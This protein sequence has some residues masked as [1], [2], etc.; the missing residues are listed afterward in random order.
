MLWIGTVG[1]GLFSFNG[2]E[3]H[4]SNSGLQ[5]NL[6]R[7]INIDLHENIWLATTEEYSCMTEMNGIIGTCRTAVCFRIIL[8]QF[9]SD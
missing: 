6:V 9:K 2:G 3:F 8:P 7:D 5:D 1:G 4:V